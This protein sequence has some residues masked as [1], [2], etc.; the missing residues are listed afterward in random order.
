MRRLLVLTIWALSAIVTVHVTDAQAEDVGI[1]VTIIVVDAETEQPIST[2]VIRHPDEAERHP[3]NTT[4]GATSISVLY[5]VDGTEVVFTKGM[6]LT[7]E[8]SAPG[9]LNQKVTYVMR[10]RRN[11]VT[12]PLSKMQIDIEMDE[13]DD[14]VIQ[15]G[16]DKPLDGQPIDPK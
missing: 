14:P 8:V 3:V 9:F 5:M 4:T 6:Q 12:V 16:R 2:A 10:R 11:K 13:E 7:F 15:F 1:P